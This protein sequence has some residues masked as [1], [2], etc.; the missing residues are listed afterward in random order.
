MFDN[1]KTTI[2]QI[3]EYKTDYKTILNTY[4]D[5]FIFPA[6][7]YLSGQENIS[8]IVERIEDELES[9]LL[10][11]HSKNEMKKYERLATRVRE[12][13]KN[14]KMFKNCAGVENYSF[15]LDLRNDDEP[16]YTLIDYF[17]DDFITFIDESHIAIP[18]IDA[19][20]HGDQKRKA[21]LVEYGFRLPSALKNRPLTLAEVNEKLKNI[22][23]VTATPADYELKKVNHIYTEQLIRPT[24]LLDPTIEIN[25]TKT[26]IKHL[27]VM[28]NERVAKNERVFVIATTIQMVDDLTLYLQ[29]Q[30]IK[31]Q[32]LH[33]RL[34]TI[35]RSQILLNLRKGI[36]D[37]VVGV[38]LLRE[39]L[40]IP[41]VSL[42]CILEADK[43]GFLRSK[44]SLIQTIGR[45]ARNINGH[46]I[47]Y[48]QQMTKSIKDAI[49]ETCRRR[50]SQEIYNKSNQITPRSTTRTLTELNF[51]N[52]DLPGNK[53]L[54]KSKFKCPEC[55]N[56]LM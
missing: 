29:G 55:K 31:A 12:D 3:I 23:Y 21:S 2:T 33:S 32:S 13:V 42:V 11:F 20:Y 45:A 8:K 4:D 49:D 35:N 37:V 44:T 51:Y 24:G 19:M 34:T 36:F 40:D 53:V 38:N 15:H 25:D 27:I 50:E 28:I 18:Q 10:H 9:R 46:V 14:L 30:N 7:D 17:G 56:I 39:G 48:A 22:I 54:T 43:E 52:E 5:Y 26:P 47:L 6:R 41:E 16:P 1:Q